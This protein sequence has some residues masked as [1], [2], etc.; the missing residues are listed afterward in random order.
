MIADERRLLEMLAAS[1]G[2]CTEAL[3][4]THGFA[5]DLVVDVLLDGLATAEPTLAGGH[6]VRITEGG[7]RALAER[8]G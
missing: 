7:R 1:P 5:F 6:T 2:G 8:P 4:A 3:L